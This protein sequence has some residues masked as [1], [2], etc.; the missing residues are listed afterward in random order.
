MSDILIPAAVHRQLETLLE[1]ISE[2]PHQRGSINGLAAQAR[3]ALQSLQ[4]AG[5]EPVD[6]DE[7]TVDQ[8]T[9]ALAACR[10]ALPVPPIGHPAENDW[11]CAIGDPLSVPAFIRAML[12]HPPGDAPQAMPQGEWLEKAMQLALAYRLATPATRAV[13]A[14]EEALH[15]HLS[16]RIAPNAGGQ[17]EG[18]K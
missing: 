9:S 7:L 3:Y 8:L 17:S 13:R 1:W 4:R 11:A 16:L 12:A 18:G 2:T 15:A 6:S 10:D 5:G 14:S